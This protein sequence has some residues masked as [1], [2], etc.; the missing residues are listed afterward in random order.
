M[1]PV[2]ETERLRLRVPDDR[3]SAAAVAYW[4]DDRSRFTGGPMAEIPAWRH[5]AS[6]VGHWTL[7]GYGLFAVEPRAG[8]AS[9]GLVG[10]YNPGGWPEPEIGWI[11]WS[12]ASEGQGLAHEAASAARHWAW[13]VLGWRVAVSYIAPE[14]DR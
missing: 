14:N 2:I 1:S 11:L 9:L 5:W 13:S 7:R 8:G 4:M 10:C 6:V 3:E 12:A